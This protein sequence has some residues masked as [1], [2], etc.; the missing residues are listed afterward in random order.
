MRMLFV[1]ANPH[2]TERIDLAEELRTLLRCLKGHAVD[3]QLLPAA[4]PTDLTEALASDKPEDRFHIVHFAGHADDLEGLYFRDPEGLRVPFEK[5]KLRKLLENKNVKLA[6]LNACSTYATANELLQT[7]AGAAVVDDAST[8]RGLEDDTGSEL[9][10]G[11]DHE[12]EGG[13]GNEPGGSAES[14]PGPVVGA[15]ISTERKLDDGVANLMTRALYSALARRAPL[16]EAFAEAKDAITAPNET[17]KDRARFVYTLDGP[18]SSQVLFP[19]EGLFEKT[20]EVDAEEQKKFDRYFYINYLDDQIDALTRSIRTNRWILG[21][22]IAG[23]VALLLASPVTRERIWGFLPWLGKVLRGE[24]ES[25]ERPL[26]TSLQS[27]GEAIPAYYAFLQARWCVHGG[28]KLRQLKALKALVKKSVEIEPTLQT[29]LH[30]IMDESLRAA[31]TDWK[32]LMRFIGQLIGAAT[33][34]VKRSQ[35]KKQE[36]VGTP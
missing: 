21:A 29:R 11:T 25:S 5:G 16:H 36:A 35:G 26:L 33:K 1:S 14:K 23:A 10:D 9:E 24:A 6:V 28:I 8:E 15:V 20:P 18:E 22:L 13:A 17:D 12:P 30:K 19:D 2:W 3:L 4:Q 32:P 34:P 7:E 27:L 31:D